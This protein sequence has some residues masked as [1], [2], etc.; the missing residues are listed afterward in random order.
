MNDYEMATPIN[1]LKN[2]NVS[3]LVRNVEKSTRYLLDVFSIFT[4]YLL[5]IY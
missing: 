3:N 2:N 1:S 5:D 4:R